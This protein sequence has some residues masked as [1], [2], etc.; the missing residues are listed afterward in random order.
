MILTG[1]LAHGLYLSKL[2]FFWDEWNYLYLFLNKGAEDIIEFVGV[3]RASVAHLAAFLME[4]FGPT[5]WIWHLFA[6]ILFIGTGALVYLIS[7]NLAP[8]RTHEAA[9]VGLLF[10]A[11]P[12]NRIF[13][14]GI[15]SSVIYLSYFMSVASLYF[16]LLALRADV[17]RLTYIYSAIAIACAVVMATGYEVFWGFEALRALPIFYIL[18]EKLAGQGLI[19]Q[20]SKALLWWL[21]YLVAISPYILWRVFF[22]QST[23]QIADAGVHLSHLTSRPLDFLLSLGRRA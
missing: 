1:I 17:R 4:L 20:G 9:S 14:M 19:R 16:T 23:K 10:L 22:F 8:G 7:F 13:P 11:F 18:R 12:E 6:L 2:S 15:V 21:P 3:R 5:P